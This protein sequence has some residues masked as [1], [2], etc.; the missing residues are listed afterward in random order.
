[1]LVGFAAETEH[2]IE[3]ARRKLREKRLDLIVLNDVSQIDAGFDV[4]TNRV[5][6]IGAEGEAEGWPLLDKGEVAERLMDRVA[7]VRRSSGKTGA[8][9]EPRA[10]RARVDS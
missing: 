8:P 6:L 2:G 3:H 5:W 7:A 9:D 10:R 4:E 1:M